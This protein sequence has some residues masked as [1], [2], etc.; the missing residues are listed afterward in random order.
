MKKLFICFSLCGLILTGCSTKES[1]ETLDEGQIEIL[2]TATPQAS[3]LKS[4]PTSQENSVTEIIL[5]GVDASNNV[6]NGGCTPASL[7]G[8]NL[9]AALRS[10]GRAITVSKKVATLYA[11]ANPSST[12]N[13]LTNLTDLQNL[14]NNFGETMPA[15]PFMM[16]GKGTVNHTAK[17]VAIELVRAV[18]KIDIKSGT[19]DFVITSA[20]VQNTPNLGYVFARTP[21]EIP[22]GD[23][24]NYTAVNSSNPILYAAESLA[25]SGTSFNVSGT[26]NG[27]TTTT[28]NFKLT[29]GG[30]TSYINIERNTHYVVTV[31]P[32][33]E[34]ICT[35]TVTVANWKD[36]T[37]LD[38]I[39]IPYKSFN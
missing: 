34:T 2:F 33:T 3:L 13:N 37:Q 39:V 5:I 6:V 7:T 30:A 10:S 38:D 19:Q 36:G 16:S 28:Y 31:N 24:K 26:Y 35:I 1:Q 14:T 32:V 4:T 25:S 12:A 20:S 18:A 21:L 15:S 8:A 17:T 27:K 29:N 22:T 9:T 23:R 11:I